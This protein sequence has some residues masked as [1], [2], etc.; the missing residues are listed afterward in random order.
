MIEVEARSFLEK[1][2]YEELLVFMRKNSVF[3]GETNQVTYYFA[4][5]LDLRIQKNDNFSKIWMKKGVLHDRHREEIEVKFSKD[6]FE[7]L[8]RILS[9]MGYE[10]EIKWFRLRNTF[11]WEGVKV[12]VDYTRG[13]GYIVELEKMVEPG[14][15]EKAYAELEKRMKVLGIEVTP[16]E[17]FDN[18]YEYYRKNWK[19]LVGD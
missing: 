1:E 14:D 9:G 4:G 19:C 13:Y 18:R 17:I 2:K 11:S 6:D 5:P 8:E 16:K 7:A 10:V 15:E 12:T 3:L